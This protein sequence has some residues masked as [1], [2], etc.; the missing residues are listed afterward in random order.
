MLTPRGLA[1]LQDTTPLLQ[2]FVAL[3]RCAVQRYEDDTH[4]AI[5]TAA[6]LPELLGIQP[7]LATQL[8]FLVSLDSWAL[9]PSGGFP[10][11]GDMRIGISE[12][13]VFLVAGVEA[14]EAY[15]QT[16]ME[17]WYP[18]P[19]SEN[20]EPATTTLNPPDSSKIMVVHGR[21]LRARDDLFALLRAIGLQPIEWSQAIAATEQ[22]APYTGDAVEAAFRMAQAA[23]VLCTPDEEVQLRE[24]LRNPNEP[25]EARTAWQPRP[26]VF[27]EGGIAFTMHPHRTIVLELG[28]MR[29]ASDLLRRN[30]IRITSGPQWR[31]E[32]AQRLATAGC[33][34]NTS[35]TDW[36]TTGSFD[37]TAVLA[38]PL[39]AQDGATPAEARPIMHGIADQQW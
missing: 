39:R 17:A 4:E 11:Q 7:R 32:L 25:E 22:G 20:R 31:H 28:Q 5:I 10:G 23:V 29:I 9:M 33:S 13:A 18:D 27:F 21:D 36:M 37:T 34:V 1:Y 35:G 3:L 2:A 26:N 14:I 19:V 16:E 38:T 24:D 12:R 6:E 30:V 8:E 15:L